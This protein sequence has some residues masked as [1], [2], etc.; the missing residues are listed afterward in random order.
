MSRTCPLCHGTEFR[1]TQACRGSVSVI[2][3]LEPSGAVFR[4]NETADGELD[5]SDLAF[6]NPEGPFV[7]VVCGTELPDTE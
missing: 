2:V 4:R 7:C 1:A 6:D 5:A 3:T